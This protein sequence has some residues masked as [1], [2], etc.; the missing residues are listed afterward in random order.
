MKEAVDLLG[1]RLAG[2]AP[3][4]AIVLGSGLGGLVDEVVDPVR[5]PYAELPGFPASGVSGHAGA[6]VAGR[7]A[8]HRV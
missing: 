7:L 6:L 5:I 3:T 1:K 8:A 4:V 2:L